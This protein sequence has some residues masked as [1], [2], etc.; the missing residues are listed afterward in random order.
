MKKFT[1]M[2]CAS[3]FVLGS[4]FTSGCA[5]VTA[6]VKKGDERNFA[7]S[8]NDVNAGRAIKARIR[9]TE[10]FE[11]SHVDVEVAQ[12]IVVLSGSVPRPEDRIE[13]ER[14][15]WSAPRV[16]QIGNEITIGQSKGKVRNA[17]D[18]ILNNSVR[19]RLAANS[20]VKAR[21]Y[22]IEVHNGVVYLLGVARSPEELAAA[23][24][25]AS[26]TRGAREVVSYVKIAGDTQSA[27]AQGPGYNGAPSMPRSVA[28]APSA[29][30]YTQPSTPMPSAPTYTP[31]SVSALPPAQPLPAPQSSAPTTTILDD[32]AIDSG[33]PYYLDP[34]TGERIEIPEGITPIP[35]V[36]DTGPGSLGHGGAPLPP[37]TMASLPTELPTDAQLG[38]FRAGQAGEAVSV[39]ESAP[40]TLDPKTGE[41]V[42]VKFGGN[43]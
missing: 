24:Q 37:G 5:V 11:L 43:Q 15:A 40:Y 8:L 31:P 28:V 13:A 34:L 9:R 18:G 26:T 2:I 29:P 19:A 14:I 30:I 6:G 7:R 4:V 23:T 20:Y 10:G 42:P 32:D 1:M 16:T 3:T 39:I 12:G 25:V 38:Q 17:K 22:N 21:N 33:E 41:M 36:P 35:Y 27:Y